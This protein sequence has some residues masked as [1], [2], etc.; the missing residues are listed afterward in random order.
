MAESRP[1]N[2][3][4]FNATI[5]D[6]PLLDTPAAIEY[7]K[8]KWPAK[9][10]YLIGHSMGGN[11]LGLVGNL[12]KIDAAMFVCAQFGYWKLWPRYWRTLMAF[13]FYVV[14]PVTSTIFGYVPRW[15]GA[16]Q[17][18]PRRIALELAKWCRHPHY[19]FGDK[20]LD[21][22][23]YAKF[24]GSILAYSFTDDT[25]AS[26]VACD[27]LLLRFPIADID[28]RHLAPNFLN[29]TKI[30]HFGF[31]TGKCEP[32]WKECG[33]WMTFKASQRISS[34]AAAN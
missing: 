2:L 1:E 13:N 23:A 16:G 25:H 3:R 28:H 22:S 24:D 15:L 17:H 20:S 8:E 18:W 5:R 19:L 32:L 9:K 12:E 33:Q 10:L 7:L 30:G 29:L 4:K 31:F 21:S 6:W 34:N 26:K 27:A 14:V 11:I